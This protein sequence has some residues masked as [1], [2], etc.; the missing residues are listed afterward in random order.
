VIQPL[1]HWYDG[2]EFLCLKFRSSL[3]RTMNRK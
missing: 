2:K 3:V 1:R